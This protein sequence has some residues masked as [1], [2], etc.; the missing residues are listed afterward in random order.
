MPSHLVVSTLRLLAVTGDRQLMF[1]AQGFVGESVSQFG[2]RL[3]E[4]DADPSQVVVDDPGSRLR[5]LNVARRLACGQEDAET[6]HPLAIPAYPAELCGAFVPLE[7]GSCCPKSQP[8]FPGFLCSEERFEDLRG[9]L[10]CDAGVCVTDTDA[11]SPASEAG[12]VV[13]ATQIIS[14]AITPATY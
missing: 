1:R 4:V 14:W 2:L 9:R 11:K 7:D 3:Q 6:G 5:Q 13:R 8:R 10:L 12:V